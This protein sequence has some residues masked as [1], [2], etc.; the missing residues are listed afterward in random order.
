MLQQSKRISCYPQVF[1][2][3]VRA[4]KKLAMQL[5]SH[6]CSIEVMGIAERIK[7]LR[8]RQGM[9]QSDLAR[10][11]GVSA[12]SV[13]QWEKPD[14][15]APKRARLA[16]VAE[17]LGVTVSDIVAETDER[18]PKMRQDVLDLVELLISMGAQD[19]LGMADV[20][21]IRTMLTRV[22]SSAPVAPATQ[23]FRRE[24]DWIVGGPARVGPTTKKKEN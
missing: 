22:V 20:A 17:A 14:G 12:Q 19:K 1:L 15:T 3:G 6:P 4:Q 23:R 2:G 16:S 24:S 10:K 21:L 18:F 13:Q 8:V 7:E 5:A 11:L 9:S